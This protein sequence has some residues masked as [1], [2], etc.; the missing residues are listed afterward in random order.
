MPVNSLALASP[1]LIVA[2]F[3]HLA[4]QSEY[5]GQWSPELMGNI[6]K[7]VFPHPACLLQGFHA[8]GFYALHVGHQSH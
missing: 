7:E 8:C 2:L 6:R 5:N 4:A 3:L 1:F